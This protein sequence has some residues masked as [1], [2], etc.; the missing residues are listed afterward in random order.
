MEECLLFGEF[1]AAQP[2][3][4]DECKAYVHIGQRV[5]YDGPWRICIPCSGLDKPDD[6]REGTQI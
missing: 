6:L 5:F 3:F 1:I 4:C 2:G